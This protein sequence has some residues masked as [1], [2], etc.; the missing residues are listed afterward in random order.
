MY[1][2]ELVRH[3]LVALI[4]AA[5]KPLLFSGH[6]SVVFNKQ[7]G[8]DTSLM[9]AIE[10][11]WIGDDPSPEAFVHPAFGA[12]FREADLS[13]KVISKLG[14]IRQIIARQGGVDEGFISLRDAA[15]S[16]FLFCFVARWV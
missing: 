5:P 1:L 10:E 12:D 4:D 11:A 6:S 3:I 14:C 7:Y 13:P 8:F 9:S 15:V 16:S 2:G